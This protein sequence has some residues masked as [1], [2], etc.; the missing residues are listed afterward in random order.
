MTRIPETAHPARSSC[1]AFPVLG[2]GSAWTGWVPVIHHPERTAAA[3][4]RFERFPRKTKLTADEALV[5]A[6]RVL[7][8]RERRAADK[9]RRLEAISHPRYEG[10]AA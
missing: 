2:T 9:R 7:W 10:R 5:Y 3:Y 8:Y 4:T 6:A 1:M